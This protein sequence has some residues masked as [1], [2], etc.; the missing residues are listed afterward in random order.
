MS[1]VHR[2]PPGKDTPDS[3]F[4]LGHSHC[5]AFPSVWYVVVGIVSVMEG[6]VGQYDE[7][8]QQLGKIASST[9]PWSKGLVH[10]PAAYPDVLSQG[11]KPLA[12]GQH[13]FRVIIARTVQADSISQV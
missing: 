10:V 8:R 1:I 7:R 13:N 5:G 3:L 6:E 9:L 12:G 2:A 4:P 11:S